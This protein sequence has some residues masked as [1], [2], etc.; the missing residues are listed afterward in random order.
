MGIYTEKTIIQKDSCTPVFIVALFT[1]ARSWKQPKCPS[2]DEWIKKKWYIYTILCIYYSAIKR[3]EIGSFVETWM[4]L[5]TVTQSEVSQKEK[6][7]YRILTH[8]CGTQKIG[9]D[10]PVCRAEI[11]IPM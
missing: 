2:T 6:N 10:E 7:K 3:N 8:I 4:D 9:T 5:E 1:I 11:E